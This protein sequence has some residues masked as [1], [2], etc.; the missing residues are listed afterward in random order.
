MI[1]DLIDPTTLI[2][3]GV[4]LQTQKPGSLYTLDVRDPRFYLSLSI[5]LRLFSKA[6][7]VVRVPIVISTSVFVIGFGLFLYDFKWS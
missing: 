5:L 1:L 6:S 2:D 7:G 4:Y 3:I